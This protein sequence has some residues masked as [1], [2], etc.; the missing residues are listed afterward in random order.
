[1]TR[2]IAGPGP[3]V[4][5]EARRRLARVPIDQPPGILAKALNRYARKVYGQMPDNGW[6]VA[7]N[8]R[9]LFAILGFE[10]KVA[11]FDVVP[12]SLTSLAVMAASMEIGCSWCVDFGYFMAH[13]DGLDVDK[14][15]AVA[16]WQ[17]S[18][19]F[20]DLE[21]QVIA[22]AVAATATPSEVTDDLVEPLRVALG[23]AGLVEL[24]TMVAVENQ[25]SRLNS[26]LGLVSQGFSAVC[27]LPSST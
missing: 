8:R 6:A 15:R 3:G 4:E 13:Q 14:L 24:A 7:A 10:R 16:D 19:V 12:E 2:V 27:Q 23:D 9:V 26:S 21:R 11:K 17:T 1:M 25:R 5:L 22:F 18:E 20:T